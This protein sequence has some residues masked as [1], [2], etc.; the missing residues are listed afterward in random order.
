MVVH[1]YLLP[2]PQ[3]RCV[4]F[5]SQLKQTIWHREPAACFDNTRRRASSLRTA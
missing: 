1:N 2:A 4:K 3:W 5:R